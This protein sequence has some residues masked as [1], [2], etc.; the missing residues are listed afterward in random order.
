MGPELRP[1]ICRMREGLAQP[2]IARETRPDGSFVLRSRTPLAPFRRSVI[3]WLVHWATLTP[4][5]PFL[6]ERIRRQGES[7]SW[8]VVTYADALRQTRSIGQALLDLAA[9]PERPVTVLSDNSINHA[10]M[11]LAAML[12]GR[13]STTVSSAYARVAKD[14][15]KLHGILRQLDPA[16]VYVED[17]DAYGHALAVAPLDCPIVATIAPKAG[18]LPFDALLSTA[19][20]SDVDAA[21][22]RIM[23][24]DI[25]KL[26]LTSGSTGKPKLVINTHGMLSANQQMIAQCWPFVDGAAP[27]VVDWLPWSH[28]FGANHNFNLVL[29]NGGTLYVDDGRPVPGLIER[30]VENLRDVAPTLHFNVPR[31]FDALAPFLEADDRFAARFFER[32]QMLFYAAASLPPALRVRFERVAVRHREAPVFFA[33]AWGSTE[34]SPVVTSVHFHH[35]VAGN[36][37]VP[38]PGNELKFVP[39]A[40]KL[41]MRVRGPSVFPGYLNDPAASAA[42]FDEEGFYRIGDAGKLC[43]LQDPNAGVVFDGRIAEDFKLSSGTWVS[44]GTLRLKAVGALAPFALDVAVAGHDRD[45]IGLLI[46]P[47]PALRALAADL[48]ISEESTGEQLGRHPAVRETV[49]E[50]LRR[51]ARDSGTSQ[52]AARAVILSGA[53]SLEAGEITDKGYVNQRAVLTLRAD[54]VQR[55]FSNVDSVIVIE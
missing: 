29:R 6:A 16:L 12:V 20:S 24:D 31:G 11:T 8:R 52:R 42:A 40:G 44:V 23:P 18:W 55:L 46:F 26:L 36:I 3:D 45:E 21:Y 51:M 2:D 15:T 27:V 41:E 10:L 28:T 17:G 7:A 34:T 14:M 32:L 13:P 33:S 22:A 53:P 38:T 48:P 37:G 9:A 47:A 54:D 43:D 35:D 4:D 1:R 5:V 49:L 25:A 30:T 39:C 50:G 19:A